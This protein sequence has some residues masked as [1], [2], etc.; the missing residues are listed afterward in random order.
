MFTDQKDLA[1]G[2]ITDDDL[3]TNKDKNDVC[4][5]CMIS[6]ICN[7]CLGLNAYQ[8]GDVFTLSDK[9]CTMFKKMVERAII[10]FT[11]YV[12]PNKI[13]IKS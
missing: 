13:N 10:N 5:N 11:D 7:G 6:T 12:L 2:N 3:F 1:L 4:R 9:T 8:S